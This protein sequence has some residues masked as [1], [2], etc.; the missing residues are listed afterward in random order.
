[1]KVSD[2]VALDV[3]FPTSVTQAGSDAVHTDPDY[4]AA[5]AIVRTDAGDGVEGHGLTFTIGRGT[6]VCVA[7]IEAL[8]PVVVGRDVDDIVGD[9]RAFSL[10][11]TND[12]QLRWIGPEKG[13]AHLASAAVI[14]A[15]W[16]LHAKREEKPLWKVLADMTPRQLVDI[17]DFRYITDALSPDE[18]LD[19]LESRAPTRAE[20]E[21]ELLRDGYPAYVTS[22]GWI[23][24]DDATI[25]RLCGE[26][27]ADGWSAMKMKVGQGID[28]DVRRARL[29]RALL[30]PEKRLM[31]DANQRWDVGEAIASIGRLAPFDPYWM[32]EPTSPDDVL[33][34]KAIAH[35]VAPVRL[36]TGEHAHNRVMFKQFFQAGAIGF[37]QLD[38]CRLAGVNEVLAVL[39]MAAKFGVPVC[40]HA[41]GV[42]LCEYVQHISAFDHIAVSGSL[43][44]RMVEY[45]GHLHEHFVDPVEVRGGRYVVP[46]MPG[47][48]V[49]M[50][51]E[52]IAEYAFPDGS[53]WR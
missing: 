25:E 9:W 1:M 40:P 52:S 12:S 22:V 41:G 20:R 50:K 49:E 24:Y 39:L 4:S 11:L 26:A 35:A 19:L 53:V 36:A 45:A 37:C 30:G 17:V 33:G 2:L 14:N 8:R 7:A 46:M 13:A 51:P 38:A 23:G 34:H 5:Y 6:E 29:L 48:S 32:E 18:A 27:M 47:Y 21:A 43:D 44:D 16:D 31:M 10:S 28:D 42:G 15:L 3:R